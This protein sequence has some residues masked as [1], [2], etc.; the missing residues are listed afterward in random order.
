M[1]LY[2]FFSL[3]GFTE[4]VKETADSEKVKLLTLEDLYDIEL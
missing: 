3:S 4:W 1:V 2:V